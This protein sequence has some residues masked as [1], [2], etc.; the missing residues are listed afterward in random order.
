[1]VDLVYLDGL[2]SNQ[3]QARMNDKTS[4][5]TPWSPNEQLFLLRVVAALISD[6]AASLPDLSSV[7]LRHRLTVLWVLAYASLHGIPSYTQPRFSQDNS[8]NVHIPP[9]LYEAAHLGPYLH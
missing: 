9:T 8:K 1:M 2:Y 6:I 5:S 3:K 4:V 7:G